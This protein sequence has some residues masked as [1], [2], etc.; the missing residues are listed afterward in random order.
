MKWQVKFLKNALFGIFPATVQERLRAVKRSFLPAD[1]QINICTLRQGMQQVD[2]LKLSGCDPMGKDYLELGTG[3][4]PVIPLVF[5]LAGCKSLT[6]VDSQRLMDG[7]AFAETCRK[8]LE[9][10]DEIA[11]KLHIAVVDIEERLNALSAMPLE[12][13]LLELNCQYMA[14]YDLLSDGIPEHS[15]DIISSIAVLEHVPPQ[16]VDKLFYKF[17]SLLRS[18]GVMCHII[19]NSDHWEFNDKSIS[20]LN[21]L[22]FSARA[23]DFI[24]SMNPLDYQNRLRHSQ[25]KKMIEAAGFRVVY[26]ESPADDKAL[27]ELN[28]LKIHDDFNAFSK[29]DLAVLTSYIVATP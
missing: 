4:S 12:S 9:Y 20:R 26:E 21:F 27:A 2:L 17:N 8:L 16:I 24:S 5:S 3:W 18:T 7:Y 13:A 1:V 15:L 25:Y 14:P 22:T 10:K 6:L 23:F 28:T 19:D 11:E 29:Q